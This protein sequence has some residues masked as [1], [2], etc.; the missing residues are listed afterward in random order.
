MA[1]PTIT[2]STTFVT[3]D[4]LQSPFTTVVL[5]T[6][7]FQ[8]QTVTI[9][10]RTGSASQTQPIVVSSLAQF[11]T[12][13]NQPNGF[14]TLQANGG[15][16]S[17]LNAFPF[18]NQE[19]SSGVSFLTTSTLYTSTNSTILENLSSVTVE[20]LI[21]TGRFPPEETATFVKNLLVLSHTETVSSFFA[22]SAFTVSSLLSTF[23]SFYMA[24]SL[25]VGG[26][27]TIQSTLTT[28]SSLYVSSSLT[29]TSLSSAFVTV[30]GYL[31]M[32]SIELQQSTSTRPALNLGGNLVVQGGLT[33]LSSF[34]TGGSVTANT[35][36]VRSSLS[37]VTLAVGNSLSISTNIS[38]GGLYQQDPL[39]ITGFS[40]FYGTTALSSVSAYSATAKNV[41]F[42]DGSL[43]TTTATID[44][45]RV[46]RNLSSSGQTVAL[47]QVSTLQNLSVR[48]LRISSTQV[49]VQ[50]GFSTI[51][52]LLQSG[53]AAGSSLQLQGSV[54]SPSTLRVGGNA[55]LETVQLGDIAFTSSLALLS[56]LTVLNTLSINT[57]ARTVSTSIV[58]SMNAASTVTVTGFAQLSS[59][60]LPPAA[61]VN[62]IIVMNNFTAGGTLSTATTTT[63]I[64]PLYTSSLGIGYAS[65]P[66]SLQVPYMI[67][68][69]FA[70]VS[71]LLSTTKIASYGS[72][73]ILSSL[74]VGMSSLGKGLDVGGLAKINGSATIFQTI[75]SQKL[76]SS[77]ITGTLYG[78]GRGFYN[79]PL[80]STVSSSRITISSMTAYNT[81]TGFFMGSSGSIFP[82]LVIT[83]TL[84]IQNLP[85]LKD[86]AGAIQFTTNNLLQAYPQRLLQLNNSLFISSGNVGVNTSTPKYALHVEGS[87]GIGGIAG[88]TFQY[89]DVKYD[90]L[91]LSTVVNA[92]G[93]YVS[94]VNSGVVELPN[95]LIDS[96]V[97]NNT[98]YVT[99]YAGSGTPAYV[100]GT[101]IRASFNQP[102][103]IAV[104]SAFNVYVGDTYNHCIR[105]I[106]PSGVVSTLAGSGVLGYADGP[107]ISASFNSPMG[108][109]LDSSCNVYVSDNMNNRIRK[110]TPTGIVTTVAGNGVNA[111]ADGVGILTSFSFPTGITIDSTGNLYVA[112][113][114]NNRIRKIDPSSN[115]T[116]FAGSGTPTFADG[117]GTGASF[118]SPYSITIDT[119]NNLYVGDQMN[120]RIRKID[121]GAKVTSI[122]GNGSPGYLDGP[123]ASAQVS[124]VNGLAVYGSTVYFTD[125]FNN[126]IRMLSPSGSVSTIGGNGVPGFLGTTNGIGLTSRFNSPSGMAVD[127]LGNLYV[128]DQSNNTVRK[129]APLYNLHSNTNR[130]A[131]TQSTI[132]INNFL[133][134][135]Q[136]S[137]GVLVSSPNYTLDAYSLGSAS[138]ATT[139]YTEVNKN[140]QISQNKKS[141]W[142]ATGPTDY[143]SY[144]NMR[145]SLTRGDNW[146][147]AN[148]GSLWNLTNGAAY[149][150]SYWVS[151][152]SP[153]MISQDGSNWAGVD[154]YGGSVLTGT[155]LTGGG[156]V[157]WNGFYWVATGR[158]ATKEGTLLKSSDGINWTSSLSGGFTKAGSYQ[159]ND[160]LWTGKQWI[161]TGIAPTPVS[162]IQ[163]SQDGLNWSSIT[164][165]GFLLGGNSLSLG[166]LLPF[167]VGL[168][169]Y[170]GNTLVFAVGN[171]P[172]LSS[173]QFSYDGGYSW[174]NIT[175]GGFALRGNGI[176]TDGTYLVAGGTDYISQS[177]VQIGTIQIYPLK[178]LQVVFQ[179]YASYTGTSMT[180]F[181][182]RA[183]CVKWNGYEWLVGGDTGVRKFI[184]TSNTYFS[185]ITVSGITSY[186]YIVAIQQSL[187]APPLYS[188]N[189]G[190]SWIEG[191]G[192]PSFLNGYLIETNGSNMWVMIGNSDPAPWCSTDGITWN[193][194]KNIP[195]KYSSQ[196]A[197]DLRYLN[198]RWLLAAYDT[199]N[200]Y[201]T[202]ITSVDGINWSNTP[203]T[204]SINVIN[205]IL[206]GNGLYVA[207]LGAFGTPYYSYDLRTW[208]AG[209]GATIGLYPNSGSFGNGAF[210][211]AG[212][213][214]QGEANYDVNGTRPLIRSTDGK[215]WSYV[216][217]SAFQWVLS[218]A[219]FDILT[220][221]Y[222]P[223]LGRFLLGGN[224]RSYTTTS[225]VF[226]S[227]DGGISWG[228]CSGID[229]GIDL[230]YNAAAWAV[231]QFIVCPR[232]SISLTY[233]R[234]YPFYFSADGISFTRGNQIQPGIDFVNPYSLRASVRYVPIDQSEY[235]SFAYSS[236]VYS[237]LN[238]SSFSIYTDAD[239]NTVHTQAF[240][241]SMVINS[242][243]IVMND[244]FTVT[245]KIV[246]F[247]MFP[248][249][250]AVANKSSLSIFQN[251]DVTGSFS[252]GTTT[253]SS[254]YLG[255]QSV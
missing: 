179:S 69:Q 150:G 200:N 104:D 199:T 49:A 236:N 65:T 231:S 192:I 175:S 83:S 214:K 224:T 239:I 4:S 157:A 40:H 197:T 169:S 138:N 249:N 120:Y 195:F 116:T 238:T 233:D 45:A 12:L 190:A 78:D 144:S 1:T 246:N 212:F 217:S 184:T 55:F 26:S 62:Q 123:A 76:Y 218:T 54:T 143:A 16:W 27:L 51:S 31:L 209:T 202:L 79:V 95:L 35:L 43:Q 174:S 58:G 122:V 241:N 105:V 170:A 81:S 60:S 230:A 108:L 90:T 18:W 87:L 107:N 6:I 74:A 181:V 225:N 93:R 130:M 100:N 207:G 127:S 235:T 72:V 36:S 128:D 155:F 156:K 201:S 21:I 160:I 115:V 91:V 185:S 48:S 193:Q 33:V 124:Y 234:S 250:T 137:V 96:T 247:G 53:F 82:S 161:A 106:S 180:D 121:T 134:I 110:I 186:P 86:T 73:Q 162:S 28:L 133:Y 229:A 151:P 92:A 44:T 7:G 103:G 171:D 63:P 254:L 3:V 9:I 191:P 102:I 119:A 176:D 189:N 8:G 172:Y 196:Q 68:S 32:S 94:Y 85:I 136:S 15:S 166:P 131:T 228:A 221:V 232:T 253:V 211:M 129:I 67:S 152:G 147:G 222:S 56:S 20:N 47:S 77:T 99:T 146:L 167:S 208:T 243:T 25:T 182:N 37:T 38:S 84:S 59:Y 34:T 97:D 206:Y 183:N 227:S 29:A 66:Y 245:D 17:Y 165:G 70:L 98:Y 5:S 194:I 248:I 204:P 118:N 125:C 251:I 89:R 255:I 148:D 213:T 158:S 203:G 240:G 177:N 50:G 149:N 219:W 41:L 141:I 198:N 57:M 114:G 188:S 153:I 61:T 42:L 46:V 52:F 223:L 168:E 226:Y 252:S 178:P 216:Y 132:T 210:I 10:D 173:I 154:Y 117:V 23:S 30:S 145:Y 2:P 71:S 164:T 205:T 13:I 14:L 112:D 19:I 135:G 113:N 237:L 24:S 88:I 22:A 140:I 11:S 64:I 80:Q 142:V 244:I 163:W 75:S 109:V 215:T 187:V 220:I 242:N 111:Y 126:T 139:Y 101:G 39:T 159:G